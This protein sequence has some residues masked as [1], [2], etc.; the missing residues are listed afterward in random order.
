MML[1]TQD[2]EADQNMVDVFCDVHRMPMEVFVS[3]SDRWPFLVLSCKEL[4]CT[5]RFIE[6]HGY[7]NLTDQRMDISTQKM[8]DCPA[9]AGA[10][11]IVAIVE[12]TLFWNCIHPD[13]EAYE[14]TFS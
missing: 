6:L 10:V 14:P 12:S 11:A 13:C 2:D 1:N 3:R 4:G 7:H 5:R 8:K 9:H